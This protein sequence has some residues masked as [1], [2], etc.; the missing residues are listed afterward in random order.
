MKEISSSLSISI[1]TFLTSKH[2]CK[3]MKRCRDSSTRTLRLAV[4]YIAT[5][6]SLHNSFAFLIDSRISNSAQRSSGEGRD[7]TTQLLLLPKYEDNDPK[8]ANIER[9]KTNSFGSIST[10]ICMAGPLSSDEEC[11]LI[12]ESRLASAGNC[13]PTVAHGL[14]CPETIHKMEQAMTRGR[15]N[16]A[17]KSFLDRYHKLGPMSC[18]ELLSD[19]EILPHLTNTMR[20]LA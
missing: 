13:M 18:M 20:D 8:D 12:G 10:R 11:G 15:T 17:V 5:G 1:F 2:P 9:E 3:R 4:L 7:G 19:P 14:L 6:P 16:S